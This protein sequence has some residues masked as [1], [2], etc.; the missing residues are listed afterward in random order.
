MTNIPIQ[1]INNMR[2]IFI[3]NNPLVF[4]T[5]KHLMIFTNIVKIKSIEQI[6]IIILNYLYLKIRKVNH[7][8]QFFYFY[9]YE[10]E[11][12]YQ[13]YVFVLNKHS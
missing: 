1:I 12:N 3:K 2:E 4:F 7:L 11:L 10:M 8:L 13:V 6:I 9:H 5:L